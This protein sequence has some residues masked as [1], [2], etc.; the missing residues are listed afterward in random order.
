MTTKH[1]VIR[2]IAKLLV[3]KTP[4]EK[5]EFTKVSELLHLLYKLYRQEKTFRG[6]ILNPAVPKEKKMGFLK[7]LRE[8]LGID[9]GVDGVLSYILDVNAVPLLGEVKRVYDYEVEKLLRVSKALLV[10]ARKVDQSEIEKIEEVIKRF[11]GREYEFEVVEDPEL[12]GGFLL[13]TSSL[14]VDATVK[15]NLEA[16]LRG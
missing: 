2:K 8:K 6:F 3:E 7:S 11:T 14:V 5:K 13:K 16:I 12:I 10:L 9:E 4:K 15:R 1:D